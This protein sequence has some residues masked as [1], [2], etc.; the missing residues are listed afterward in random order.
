M[1]C[2][3][4]GGSIPNALANRTAPKTEA[5]YMVKLIEMIRRHKLGGELEEYFA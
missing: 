5:E 2:A 1:Q 3:N 4:P